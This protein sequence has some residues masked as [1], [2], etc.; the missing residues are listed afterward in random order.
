MSPNQKNPIYLASVC[1]E[2]NRWTKERIPTLKVSEWVKH[3]H[4]AGFDGLE[5]WEDHVTKTDEVEREKI[6]TGPLPVAIFNSYAG[7]SE[8]ELPKRDLAAKLANDFK[9]YGLKYNFS[10]LESDWPVEIEQATQW[11]KRFPKDFSMLC[12]CHPGTSAEEPAKA[13]VLLRQLED[14]LETEQVPVSISAIL[15]PFSSGSTH[16]NDWLG[17]LGNRLVHAHV[18]MRDPQNESM[19]VSIRDYPDR[20]REILKRLLGNGF[21]GSFT[22]EFVKG[23]RSATENLVDLFKESILD[24]HFLREE[25]DR[26]SL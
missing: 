12:E 24:L 22:V 8:S 23:T 9:S 17:C 7:L 3:I 26:L 4:T 19:V 1:L 15:H 13:A 18:Q 21:A 11:A 20:S 25:L 14:R 2:K 5:L 16:L 6:L 10:K